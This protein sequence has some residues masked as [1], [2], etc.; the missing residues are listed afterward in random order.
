MSSDEEQHQ[1]CDPGPNDPSDK[2]GYGRPPIATRFKKG[3]SGN[4]KGRPKVRKTLGAM[5]C[6]ALDEKLTFREGGRVRR[7]SK[8][9]VMIQVALN[10]ALKGKFRDALKFIELARKEGAFE[11]AVP[12]ITGIDVTIVHPNEERLIELEAAWNQRYPDNTAGSR[13]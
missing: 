5:V 3:Q 12:P 8:I 6:E 2:V 1:Q 11:P 13:E 7:R 10:Q 9:E 4:P